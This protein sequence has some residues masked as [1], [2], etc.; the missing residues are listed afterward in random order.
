MSGGDGPCICC[1]CGMIGTSWYNSHSDSGGWSCD[2]CHSGSTDISRVD[3]IFETEESNKLLFPG[4]VDHARYGAV[5]YVSGY[6]GDIKDLDTHKV[7]S[8]YKTEPFMCHS[9][10][11]Y[12]RILLDYTV[13]GG[14]FYLFYKAEGYTDRFM[15]AH[16]CLDEKT[17]KRYLVDNSN[18]PVKQ[19]RRYMH[20]MKDGEFIPEFYKIELRRQRKIYAKIFEESLKRGKPFY[21]TPV[22]LRASVMY[23]IGYCF[24]SD[25][26]MQQRYLMS[27]YYCISS[28]AEQYKDIFFEGIEETKKYIDETKHRSPGMTMEDIINMVKAAPNDY[29]E[30]AE[31]PNVPEI[32]EGRP[33]LEFIDVSDIYKGMYDGDNGW[34]FD[35]PIKD[36]E[37]A[38][39][40]FRKHQEKQYSDLFSRY[41][42]GEYLD[43][44]LDD[45]INI[46]DEMAKRTA[47]REARWKAEREAMEKSGQKSPYA[48][49][50]FIPH[51]PPPRLF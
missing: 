45:C 12:D 10:H 44:D 31:L 3:T 39:K 19:R 43:V 26:T 13:Y 9:F 11:P 47:E 51:E 37:G 2:I 25:E 36:V 16:V 30:P 7:K 1:M 41:S 40:E 6:F 15:G 22:M 8:L 46:R 29:D 33:Y 20:E 24:G 49:C 32:L 48:P 4:H 28:I 23:G 42:N 21:L 38:E 50:G 35:D 18:W 17:H 14:K 5:K 34:R 27:E